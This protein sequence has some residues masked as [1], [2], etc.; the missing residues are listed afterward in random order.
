MT[1]RATSYISPK[2]MDVLNKIKESGI[3]G[4]LEWNGERNRITLRF[5]RGSL[6]EKGINAQDVA[7]LS[8][9]LQFLVHKFVVLSH[10]LKYIIDA[11]KL[12]EESKEE[13]TLA[14]N[15]YDPY[16][17]KVGRW[18]KTETRY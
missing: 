17:G 1:R 15:A 11:L 2:V 16:K 10:N 14:L 8:S 3:C 13:L 6:K 5:K 12:D 9:Q 18:K 7:Y 4:S